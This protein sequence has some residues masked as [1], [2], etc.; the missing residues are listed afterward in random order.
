MT[1][2]YLNYLN[3]LFGQISAE[4]ASN[5]LFFCTSDPLYQIDQKKLEKAIDEGT[6]GN[7]LKRINKQAFLKGYESYL[8]SIQ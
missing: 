3:D 1:T 2:A 4:Q 6:V 5:I 7:L 8:L